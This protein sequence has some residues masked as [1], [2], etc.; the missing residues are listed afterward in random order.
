MPALAP[1]LSAYNLRLIWSPEAETDLL[2]IWHWGAARFSPVI[3]DTHLRDIQR[4]AEQLTQFPHTGVARD[5]IVRGIRS[6]V[7]YP[8]VIFYRIN[9]SSIDIIRVIDGRRNIAALFPRDK[10]AD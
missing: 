10:F 1:H 7:V 4:A 9:E 2:S 3:A 8:T 6:I 5:E